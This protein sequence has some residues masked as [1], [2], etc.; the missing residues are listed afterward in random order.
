MRHRLGVFIRARPAG[1]SLND[2]PVAV[3]NVDGELHATDDTCTHE[4]YSLAEG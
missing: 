2:P 4:D 1:S 3:W